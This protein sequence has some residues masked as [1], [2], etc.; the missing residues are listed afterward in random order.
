MSTP[1]TM[2]IDGV[3]Y[4]RA[5]SVKNQKTNTDGLEYVIVRGDRSG[6]FAGFLAAGDNSKTVTL[7]ECRRLWY[8]SGASSISQIAE[9]GVSK[10]DKCKF[11]ASVSKAQITDVIEILYATQNAYESI[12]G[13]PVWK[14]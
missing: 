11:P 8:W 14:S 6:V 4:I 5:D 1:K 7:L 3:D 12:K 2:S 10:P 13:V 9:S